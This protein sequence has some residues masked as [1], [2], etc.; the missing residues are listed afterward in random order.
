MLPNIFES[1][2]DHRVTGRCTYELNELLT[3]ALLTYISNGTDYTDM[4]EFVELMAR[5]LGLLS[6]N[7]T[8]P[9]PD[10]F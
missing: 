9:S 3:I 5:D 4:A 10:T 2:A 6:A 7:D 1:I 8:S